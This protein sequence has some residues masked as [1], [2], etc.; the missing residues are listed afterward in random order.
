MKLPDRDSGR[1]LP[2]PIVGVLNRL[3]RR[4]RHLILFRGLCA[5]VAAGGGAF[6]TVM[7]LDA[8]L[9]FIAAWPRWVL[10]II[11]YSIWCGV[12]YW[13]LIRP[14]AHSFTITG[15]AR[16][17][18]S[19]HPELQE[20]ISSAVELLAS[21]DLPS[22]R[23]SE[24]LIQALTTEAVQ[25]AE[26]LRPR[27]EI[28]FRMALPFAFT[29]GLLIVILAALSM[30]MPKKTRFLM[31]RAAAPFLN[32]PN[33]RAL[34]L[35]IEPG[36]TLVAAGGSLDVR[37]KTRNP[38]VTSARLRMVDAQERETRVDM[39]PVPSASNGTE[40]VFAVTLPGVHQEFRYRVQAGDAVSR[41][42]KVRV[43]VPPVIGQRDIRYRYPSYTRLAPRLDRDGSGVIRA[44]AGTEVT[45]S[46]QVNKPVRTA[47]L[48]ITSGVT[49]N[50][51]KGNWI[52][53]REAAGAGY[54]FSLVLP[55][56][57]N[58]VWTLR[59]TDEI[60]LENTPFTHTIQSL[61]DAPP[62]VSV[63]NPRQRELRLNRDTRLPV[64]YAAEDDF[65]LQAVSLVLSL[66]GRS[67][68]IVRALPVPVPAPNQAG[69]TVTGTATLDLGEALFTNVARLS[70]RMLAEDNLPAELKGSQK[71][72]SEILTI[73]LDD[74]ADS[75]R[76][77]VLVTQDQRV[78]EGLK[79]AQQQLVKAQQ[80]SK[81]LETP[82]AQ[83]PQLNA[84]T[85]HRIDALQ[86]SLA[87]A[88]N[89]LRDTAGQLQKGFFDSMASNLNV[90]AEEHV[91]RAESQAGQ[92]KLMDTQVDRV[93]MNSNVASEI[94]RSLAEIGDAIRRH[95]KAREAARKA[96]ALDDVSSRQ[97]ELAEQRRKLDT[98]ATSGNTNGAAAAVPQPAENQ[99]KRDQDAVADA[100]AR[101]TRETPEAAAGFAG[102][103][104]NSAAQ[105][106]VRAGELANKQAE[107]AAL[108]REVLEK[109]Q[110]QDAQWRELARQQE[111]LAR[112]A[113][114]TPV[115]APQA[116]TMKKAAQEMES[117]D[118]D[119][120]QRMQ[121][122][123]AESL[124]EMAR[125]MDPPQTAPSA[126]KTPRE[127]PVPPEEWDPFKELVEEAQQVQQEQRAIRDSRT[128]TPEKTAKEAV[129]NAEK[130][131]ELAGQAAQSAEQAAKEAR[132]AARQAEQRA[133]TAKKA[134][135]QA[136]Q[137]ANQAE[138]QSK[139]KPNAPEAAKSAQQAKD[140][141]QAASQKESEARQDAQDARQAGEEAR[142]QAE[143]ARQMA[144]AAR[145]SAAEAAREAGLALAAES[146]AEAKEKQDAAS[147][148]AD[149]AVDQARQAAEAAAR[150]DTL[151]DTAKKEA[152][153]PE[154]VD[155]FREMVEKAEDIQAQQQKASENK[156]QSPAEAAKESAR[157]AEQARQVADQAAKSAEQAAQKAEQSSQAAQAQASAA[158]AAAQ[159]AEQAVRQAEQAAQQNKGKPGEADA[160]Q[161]AAN[162]KRDAEDA[163]RDE[164]EAGDDARQ[165]QQAAREARQQAQEAVKSASEAAQAAQAASQ[166]AR[167]SSMESSPRAARQQQEATGEAAEQA[168]GKALDAARAAARAQQAAE[169]AR[170]EAEA[171][172][173]ADLARQQEE[174]QRDAQD[175][176]AGEQAT[177][178]AL[179][180][181][182]AEQTGED[183]QRL[184]QAVESMQQEM[185]RDAL[186]QGAV[187]QA[188]AAARAAR[189]A[190]DRLRK[191]QQSSA[192]YAAAEA[193]E[194]LEQLSAGMQE[195]L[196]AMQGAPMEKQAAIAQ[197][198]RQARELA[199]RQAQIGRQ[200]DAL[201]ADR[202]LDALRQQ[203]EHTALEAA[204][205]ANEAGRIREQASE[206]MAQPQG[207]R[208]SAEA[209]QAAQ[210]MQ[211]ARASAEQAAQQMQVASG[212]KSGQVASPSP[213]AMQQA[214]QQAAQRQQQAAQAMQQAAGNLQQASRS[215]GAPAPAQAAQE[216]LMEA[217]QSAREA[218]QSASVADSAQAAAQLQQ[219]ARQADQQARAMGVDP[220]PALLQSAAAG[221]TGN[222][223]LRTE[224][225]EVPSLSRRV[226]LKL[227]DWL[228]LHG[229]LKDDVLQAIN[230]EGPE[231]YRPI[232]QRYFREVSR[233]GE[234]K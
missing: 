104:S 77:Q 129:R 37:M 165:A 63:T 157:D 94:N 154:E 41:F 152:Q 74:A 112:R 2:G 110:K 155:P 86:D 202:P 106:A 147:R 26:S 16:L 177:L 113:E 114:I 197:Q 230:S 109:R 121:D 78:G 131:A 226:G 28:S 8:A 183:Q 116:D 135:Q 139:N 123:L 167:Q 18:E 173:L 184:A 45:V 137:A 20:R 92:I 125:K 127:N 156:V 15:M 153:T 69:K 228:R 111:Q 134:L 3:I 162:A 198:V 175:L 10:T 40:R 7:L 72:Q 5:S 176:W 208:T 203:E 205:L 38:V 178:D 229:E 161:A 59:L 124:R 44:I 136:E 90:L 206:A 50:L 216:N 182:V 195:T 214:A 218:A 100:L 95:E 179:G 30:T 207:A 57:L 54:E 122:R 82:L 75:W 158:K 9:T 39:V 146:P 174:L 70:M 68:E 209:A 180:D 81:T 1:P 23:G 120:A 163:R 225:E 107:L 221:G 13:Y 169:T 55:R 56:G 34:E 234:E 212:S 210:A 22:I 108:T 84:D 14:L 191:D 103:L 64:S 105:A 36:D 91:A 217:Y 132:Q 12:T 102:A 58:G 142:Q 118:R 29:A 164:A 223:D 87:S 4:A 27:K 119:R 201:A 96:V 148:A 166:H 232:I 219:A 188:S 32:L 83:Q 61:A 117:G 159:T 126:G 43:A 19:H 204:D 98:A 170:R 47:V 101:M 76:E 17:I 196:N 42:Y 172:Q 187:R 67:N 93:A 88:E 220:Q 115:A 65:G 171:I 85:A 145:Q 89:T 128:A 144:E 31:A 149:K 168:A 33:V 222:R 213:Q 60:G 227:Q 224:S 192:R 151:A 181:K 186:P 51:L 79:L 97:S 73:V 199:G 200:M 62:A 215:A 24:V 6:L 141:A 211:Q 130:A 140:Q 190:A 189:E 133:D 193:R 35:R 25:E 143:Q 71:G 138:Q 48:A 46:V 49:T 185:E 160:A 233:H 66:P 231:E 194:A 80:M 11:A 52:Q 53:G 21:N 99:W 150:T